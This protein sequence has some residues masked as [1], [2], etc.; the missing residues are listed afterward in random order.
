M[1]QKTPLFVLLVAAALGAGFWAPR[2]GGQSQG[3]G[4]ELSALLAQVEAQQ[5]IMA[6]NQA[7]LERQTDKLAE[8]IRVARIFSSRGGKAG[9][10]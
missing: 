4:A 10:P 1:K 8:E 7:H 9:A 5:K 2:L 3:A 6:D